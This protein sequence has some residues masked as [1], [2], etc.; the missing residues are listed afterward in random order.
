MKIVTGIARMLLLFALMSLEGHCGI[1]KMRG[2]KRGRKLS[3][4]NLVHKSLSERH[5]PSRYLKL[6][7]FM[8]EYSKKAGVKLNM[9]PK[10]RKLGMSNDLYLLVVGEGMLWL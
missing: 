3:G 1:K 2:G 4:V 6:K 10:K 9:D 7:K 5:M 8:Q